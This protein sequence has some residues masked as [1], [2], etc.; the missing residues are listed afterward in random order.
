[1]KNFTK[2]FAGIAGVLFMFSVSVVAQVTYSDNFDAAH[3]YLSDGAAGTIWE[4]FFVNHGSADPEEQWGEILALNTTDSAGVLTFTTCSVW[5]SD[6]DN[7]NGPLLYRRLP[8]GHDFEMS[9]KIASGDFESFNGVRLAYLAGGL[10]LGNPD[11][12]VQDFIFYYL[13]DRS[14]WSCIYNFT[15]INDGART[16]NFT[17]DFALSG[18]EYPWMKI[19]KTGTDLY[20][21]VSTDG[22]T[23]EEHFAETRDDLDMD[24]LVGIAVATFTDDTGTVKFESFSLTD[25]DAIDAIKNVDISNNVKV[26]YSSSHQAIIVNAADAKNIDLVQLVNLDGRIIKDIRNVGT[27]TEIV[28]PQKGLYLV[29][30]QRNGQ[31]Y[32]EK[33]VVK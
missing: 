19:T 14:E 23:W 20:G 13:F 10:Y 22:T 15:D 7:N 25:L 4:D 33:V 3:D 6:F 24:L 27:R 26:Y 2:L 21:Y 11:S 30:I 12:T 9:V 1:M 8:A 29:S 5:W 16:E 28:V 18:A 17:N 32:T 31:S